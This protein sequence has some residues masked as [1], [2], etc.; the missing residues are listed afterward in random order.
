[1]VSDL[2]LQHLRQFELNQICNFITLVQHGNSVTNAAKQLGIKQPPLSQ[3][4]KALEDLLSKGMKMDVTLFDRSRR[5]IELTEAG[6]AFLT[7]AEA[8]LGHLN[9]A[10]SKAQQACRGEIGTL[11]IGINNSIANTIL[12]RILREFK[13]QFPNV[14][15]QIQEVTIAREIQMLQHRQLDAVFLRS[16]SFEQI[17]ADLF[18]F[19][20]I[21]KEKF[22]VAVAA[23]HPLA[24][25]ET[26]SLRDLTDESILLPST[27]LFPF[28]RQVVTLCHQAGFEPKID[29]SIDVSGVVALLSLVAAGFGVSILPD[30]VQTLERQGVTYRSLEGTDLNRQIAVVCRKDDPSIVLKQFIEMLRDLTLKET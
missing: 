3:S 28:Y 9:L 25:Q 19:E 6:S 12:P 1:M 20:A 17:R 18:S 7:E 22:V 27:D 4:I 15:I 2:E 30:H 23:T 14:K 24:A 29:S 26:I 8:A 16:P 21:L 5:P 11:S 13:V 10:I